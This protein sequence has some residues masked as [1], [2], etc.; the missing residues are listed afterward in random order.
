MLT[1]ERI[2]ELQADA[3][4]DDM[5]IEP[6]MLQWTEE[7]V[8]SFFA[9][10]GA[11]TS[12]PAAEPVVVAQ[13]S[14][15]P[16]TLRVPPRPLRFLSLHGGGSN[17]RINGMQVARVRRALE[18]ASQQRIDI[19]FLEGTRTTPLVEVDPLLKKLFGD[20]PYFSWYG[21]T[22]DGEASRTNAEKLNDPSVHYT[23]VEAE[24]AL[25]RVEAFIE[26]HGPYDG[27]LGFSQG[28]I[29]LTMLTARRLRRASRGEAA[30][31]S[32]RCNVL[33]AAMPP[34][35]S[36]YTPI[37]PTLAQP[38]LSDWPCVATSASTV[39]SRSGD[40]PLGVLLCLP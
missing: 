34:R 37:Y 5:T 20:G 1:M 19:D 28:S 23:Y 9:G 10:E 16:S 13:P 33:F 18:R 21:V 17:K 15:A 24:E 11:P 14:V 3:F 26:Q 35:A 7:Q 29:M 2:L 22:N 30:P 36:E 38:P 40:T 12:A 27:L 32:W 25:D 4:A 39:A 8:K 31:P 6:T